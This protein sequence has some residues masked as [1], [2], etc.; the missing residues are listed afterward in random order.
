MDCRSLFHKLEIRARAG[1][2]LGEVPQGEYIFMGLPL[3]ITCDGSPARVLLVE[4]QT[5]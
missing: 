5:G 4:Y 1:L 3:R 2:N